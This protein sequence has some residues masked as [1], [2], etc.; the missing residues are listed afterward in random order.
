MIVS[1]S[2]LSKLIFFSFM[3]DILILPYFPL[4]AINSLF[5]LMAIDFLNQRLY[6]EKN[7]SIATLFFLFFGIISTILSYFNQPLFFSE[8]VKRIIQLTL[9]FISYYYIFSFFVRNE[10][11]NIVKLINSIFFGSVFI[12]AL[13]YF[14][15]LNIFLNYKSYF[16]KNDSFI[17][18]IESD[19]NTI[20]RFSYIWTD[21]N[22]IA[23]AIL[24]VFLF[25][26]FNLEE[27][28]IKNYIYL[29]IVFFV[30]L[31]SM[32]TT[33]WLILFFIVLPLFFVNSVSKR[34]KD[35]A[36]FL[37]FLLVT[38]ALSWRILTELLSSDVALSAIDRFKT[39]NLGS[40]SGLSRLDIWRNVYYYHQDNL[41]KYSLIGNGYQLYNNNLPI[42]SHNG[43]FLIL[44]G[45]GLPALIAFLYFFFKLKV[46]KN[47]LFMIP[48]FLCFLINVMIGETKLFLLYVYLLAYVRAQERRNI[49]K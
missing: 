13:L 46:N 24:G 37:F 31:S 9:I 12:W 23:Y 47:Y 36:I 2:R 21:P 40:D 26:I 14:I 43:I 38:L 18:F 32:S 1:K 4:F 25:S 29:C 42:A 10:S 5:F 17:G 6:F 44:F 16:N 33:A 7:Y 22:N 11:E 19:Q 34:Y 35:I 8:N 45:Y 27:S 48:F 30:C 20:Y 39:N 28:I 49:V 3:I 41:Y 15:D